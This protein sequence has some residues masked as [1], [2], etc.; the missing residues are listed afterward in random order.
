MTKSI[1]SLLTRR[2]DGS[3]DF[4][5]LLRF[6]TF[7]GCLVDC[8]RDFDPFCNCP[9]RGKLSVEMLPWSNENEEVCRRTVWFI[10]A[11]HRD[12]AAHV[13]DQTWFVRNLASHSLRQLL[14]PFLTRR[15]I[16]TLNNEAFDRATEGGRIQRSGS[17]EVKKV[18]HRF[19]CNFRRHSDLDRTE[20]RLERDALARHLFD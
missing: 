12:N 5:R 13:F 6:L 20:L 2:D 11:R 9:K 19:G 8:I 14:A 7:R 1:G 15:K 16:A 4:H 3:I 18:S 17:R 10:S